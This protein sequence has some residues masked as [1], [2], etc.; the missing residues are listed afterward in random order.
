MGKYGILWDAYICWVW[1]ER[2]VPMFS[3]NQDE[4]VREMICTQLY[5]SA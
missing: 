2:D 3:G 4:I 5:K 1:S